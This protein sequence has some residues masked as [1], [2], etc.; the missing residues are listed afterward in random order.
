M[1]QRRPKEYLSFINNI[2]IPTL[3]T[4]DQE[5]LYCDT[6]FGISGAKICQN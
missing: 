2:I 6:T 5:I 3:I 1:L 4:N